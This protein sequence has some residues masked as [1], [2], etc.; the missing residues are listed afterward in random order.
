MMKQLSLLGGALALCLAVLGSRYV[1]AA[2]G[3][4]VRKEGG[5]SAEKKVDDSSQP[6]AR[7]RPIDMRRFRRERGVNLEARTENRWE[8][9][10]KN[11]DGVLTKEELPV[12][13]RLFSAMDKDGDGKITRAEHSEGMRARQHGPGRG[14]RAD[15]TMGRLDKDHDQRLSKTEAPRLFRRSPNPDTNGDGYIS[16]EELLKV[17]SGRGERG[18]RW[19]PRRGM[20]RPLG[21]AV[22]NASDGGEKTPTGA[23][24]PP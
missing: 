24:S 16:H 12:R 10:D 23:G 8:R 6:A 21:N 14:W 9:L 5:E 13:Q 1:M 18:A 11:K 22:G 4:P 7:Q 3:E 15:R 19:L 2:E 17:F 20:I